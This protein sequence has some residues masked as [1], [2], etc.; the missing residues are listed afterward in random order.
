MRINQRFH[1]HAARLDPYEL[2][3]LL[4]GLSGKLGDVVVWGAGSIGQLQRP[5]KELKNAPRVKK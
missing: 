2:G 4:L 1:S 5:L 3:S